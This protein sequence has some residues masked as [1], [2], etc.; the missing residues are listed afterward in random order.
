MIITGGDSAGGKLVIV[1]SKP[2]GKA[3]VNVGSKGITLKLT[4]C[5]K[6]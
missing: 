3:L 4:I 5:L 2:A 1:E 6:N